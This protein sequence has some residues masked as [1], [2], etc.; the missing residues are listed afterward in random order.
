MNVST[1]LTGLVQGT[2]YSD[3]KRFNA[4]TQTWESFASS[5]FTQF[6]PG[7]GYNITGLRNAGFS[8]GKTETTTTFVYDSTGARVKKTE[9]KRYPFQKCGV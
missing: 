9:E 4:A 7:K 6:E 3:V 8:Y 5:Q 2:D 1:V